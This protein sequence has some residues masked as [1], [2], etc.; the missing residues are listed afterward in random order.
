VNKY[1]CMCVFTYNHTH[2]HH[3]YTHTYIHQH[4]HTHTHTHTYTYVHPSLDKLLYVPL[5]SESDRLAILKI[6]TA[7]VPLAE[8]TDVK[9]IAEEAKVCVCVCMYL[10]VCVCMRVCLYVCVRMC[11]CVCVRV[12]ICIVHVYPRIHTSLF[13]SPPLFTTC[14]HTHTHFTHTHTLSLSHT[15]FLR[16]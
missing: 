2:S 1:V 4:Q 11:V 8:L 14:T 15:G 13:V 10:C 7:K 9:S 12:C 3:T 16:C 6:H 5:P